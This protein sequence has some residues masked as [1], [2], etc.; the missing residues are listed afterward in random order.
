MKILFFI[1]KFGGGGAEKVLRDLVNHMDQSKFDITVQS[2]WPYEEGKRLASGVKYKTVYPV[3]NRFYE[4]LYRLEAAAKLTYPLHI[5]DDYDIE[6]AFLEMGATKIMAASTNKKAKKIAWV[7]CDL[8]RAIGNTRAF[9]EK[10]V[11]WY[12]Q[13][14]R[15]VCVSETVKN[16]FDAIFCHRFPTILLHNYIDDGAVREKAEAKLPMPGSKTRPIVL[17]VGTLY[18]PKNYPRLLKAHRRLISEGIEHELWILGDGEDRQKLERFVAD[19][20]LNG[21][22]RFF[23]FADNPYPYMKHADILACSSNYEGYSTVVTEALILGK[24]IVTTECSGMREQLGNSEFGLITDNDDEDFYFGLKQMLTDNEL[25]NSYAAKAA[26]R[27]KMI[28]GERQIRIIQET[29]QS[30]SC[31]SKE[32]IS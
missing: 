22:V 14:D 19:N 10:S 20:G 11:Q 2:V 27:G 5:R 28:S 24:P 15:V 7:H 32:T 9:A 31:Q 17:A 30:L 29:L 3:R 1:E 16:S 26:E 4:K 23:G 12:E 13:F 8:R 18:P 6:C 25:R 21:S